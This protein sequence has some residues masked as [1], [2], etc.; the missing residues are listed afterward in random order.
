MKNLHKLFYKDYYNG[1][2]FKL[3]GA[4]KV[5]TSGNLVDIVKEG[6]SNVNPQLYELGGLDSLESIIFEVQYPGLVTGVGIQHNVG[7]KEEFML[8]MHFNYTY[9]HPIVYG[10]SVKG[11]LKYYF[12][13]C[14]EGKD[15]ED[16]INDIFEGKLYK[17]DTFKSIYDRDLF[18]DAIICE[19]N[20]DNNVIDSDAITP[21]GGPKHTNKFA[22]P[23]PIPFIKIASGVKLAFRFRLVD[24]EDVNGKIVFSKDCKRKLFIKILETFGVGAKTNVGYGQLKKVSVNVIK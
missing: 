17:T 8:G 18:F 13:E 24:T 9:G 15:S 11:V 14:Y 10:S 12:K 5:V 1:V 22:E 4:N 16:L 23:T 21:H 19:A 3:N 2:T 20:A 6:K 7:V